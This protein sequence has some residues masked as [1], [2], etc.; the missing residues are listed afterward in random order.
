MDMWSICGCST[1]SRWRLDGGSH[2]SLDQEGDDGKKTPQESALISTKMSVNVLKSNAAIVSTARDHQRPF[3]PWSA[4]ILEDFYF[5]ER[6][7]GSALPIETS[8]A[9]AC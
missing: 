7:R 6:R 1:T 5:R 2:R 8:L 4:W 3:R 9:S